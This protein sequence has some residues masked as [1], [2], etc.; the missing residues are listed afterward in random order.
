M[1]YVIRHGQTDWNKRKIT[2]GRKDISLNDEGISQANDIRKKLDNYNLDLII[3]SPLNRAKETASI[4]NKDK[5]CE[6]IYDDRIM[7]R[8]LGNLEGHP[9]TN[10]NDKLW[11]IN[12][13]TKEYGIETM[14]EFKNRVYDFMDEI[15]KN[16]PDKDILLVTHGGVSALIDCYFNNNLYTVSISDKF[17]KNCSVASYD[18]SKKINNKRY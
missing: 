7:E 18:I 4:I 14:E 9:Y 12:V 13:N 5:N 2:M 17:L 10:D 15:T 6:I 8:Y 1:I 11:D 16:I 3:C